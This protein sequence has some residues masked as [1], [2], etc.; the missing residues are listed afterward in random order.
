MFQKKDYVL[1]MYSPKL[2]LY[3]VDQNNDTTTSNKQ[4]PDLISANILEDFRGFSINCKIIK[5]N[6][7]STDVNVYFFLIK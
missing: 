4:R 5:F 1:F 7:Y 6:K 2:A 3:V